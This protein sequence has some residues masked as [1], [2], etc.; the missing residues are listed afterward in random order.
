MKPNILVN[1]YAKAFL[2]LAIQNDIVDNVL[3]DLLL[4]KNTLNEKWILEAVRESGELI[5]DDF[6]IDGYGDIELGEVRKIND[7]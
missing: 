1:R 3:H 6:K 7:E 4:L 2:E 5:I